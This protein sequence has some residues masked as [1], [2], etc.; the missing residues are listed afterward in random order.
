[1][2]VDVLG[3]VMAGKK[4]AS[5]MAWGVAVGQLQAKMEVWAGKVPSTSGGATDERLKPLI[6]EA[7]K[8]EEARMRLTNDAEEIGIELDAHSGWSGMSEGIGTDIMSF[9]SMMCEHLRMPEFD[10]LLKNHLVD[11]GLEEPEERS[12]ES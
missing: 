9:A 4:L 10:V 6:R 3:Q 11:V 7:L 1:M 5:R 2:A 8:L 12:E